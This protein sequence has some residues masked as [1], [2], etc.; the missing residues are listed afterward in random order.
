MAK[1]S[2]ETRKHEPDSVFAGPHRS[3]PLTDKSH[4]EAAIR[5]APHSL[6]AGNITKSEEEHIVSE[7]KHKLGE[8]GSDPP[9]HD[10][11]AAVA[12]MHPEHVHHLVKAAHEGKFGKEAQGMAQKAMMGGSDNDQDDQAPPQAAPGRASMFTGSGPA[13]DSQPPANRASI[14]S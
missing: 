10:H 14:F 12:K 3:F 6:H 9:T 13:Q 1:L 2:T 7:A 4:D 5:D 11:K 8:K